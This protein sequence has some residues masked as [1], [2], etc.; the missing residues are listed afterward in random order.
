MVFYLLEP[1]AHAGIFRPMKDGHHIAER[2]RVWY[3]AVAFWAVVV[4]LLTARVMLLDIETLRSY[5]A[6]PADFARATAERIFGSANLPGP[7]GSM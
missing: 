3:G 1:G 7:T 4:C 6:K 2:G 5:A